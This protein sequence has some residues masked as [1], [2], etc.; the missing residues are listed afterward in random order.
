MALSPVTNCKEGEAK[1]GGDN[2]G[3]GRVLPAPLLELEADLG[4]PKGVRN[5]GFLPG[6]LDGRTDKGE[7]VLGQECG[8]LFLERFHLSTV[9]VSS[10]PSPSMATT[11]SFGRLSAMPSAAGIT[12]P[13]E[14]WT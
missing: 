10:I 7:T 3:S 4:R 13:M 6:R 11:R 2:A 14:S 8:D 9:A 5:A 1:G 12:I